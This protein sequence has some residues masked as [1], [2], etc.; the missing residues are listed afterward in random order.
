MP[1]DVKLD[2]T[3]PRLQATVEYAVFS[4]G[5]P[6]FLVEDMR[7][8]A[9]LSVVKATL[10]YDATRECSFHVFVE[11][12]AKGAVL[13]A[14]RRR[15][16]ASRDHRAKIRNGA[17]GDVGNV[18][19]AACYA[20]PSEEDGPEAIAVS[21]ATAETALRQVMQRERFVLEQIYFL[22]RSVPDIALEIHVTNCRV[23][24]IR[25]R[26]LEHIRA[27]LIQPPVH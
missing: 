3:C 7:Q 27:A 11:K 6:S 22:E 14:M 17:A 18:P 26:A 24:Q 20:M 10:R 2:V 21:R 16:L 1:L 25:D 15:D 5:I 13:D 8:E 19:L 4:C 9:W 12:C 23:R